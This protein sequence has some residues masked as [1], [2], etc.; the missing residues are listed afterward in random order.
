MDTQQENQ[1]LRTLLDGDH[2]LTI[3]LVDKMLGEETRR[4][5]HEYYDELGKIRNMLKKESVEDVLAYLYKIVG[6]G[7]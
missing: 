7:E 2:N 4:H 5:H 1:L 3:T 6:E